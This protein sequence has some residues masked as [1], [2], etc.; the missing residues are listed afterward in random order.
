MAAFRSCHI[1]GAAVPTKRRNG[2]QNTI[3]HLDYGGGGSYE[4]S[5]QHPRNICHPDCGG[6][7]VPMKR[8]N[9]IQK[10]FVTLIMGAAVPSKR[11]NSIQNYLSP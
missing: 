3:C 11:R 1:K 8:R 6:A 7:V 9:S 2:I 4:T 5:K 10:Q